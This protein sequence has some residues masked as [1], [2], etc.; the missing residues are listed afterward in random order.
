MVAFLLKVLKLPTV[1]MV[2]PGL[3]RSNNLITGWRHTSTRARMIDSESTQV[4]VKRRRRQLRGQEPLLPEHGSSTMLSVGI[5]RQCS[6]AVWEADARRWKA[7]IR[8]SAESSFYVKEK[9]LVD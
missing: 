9:V 3:K 8:R 1:I 5:E 7:L 2:R 6:R 4:L